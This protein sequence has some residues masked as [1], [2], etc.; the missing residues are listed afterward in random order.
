MP[1]VAQQNHMSTV[2]IPRVFVLNRGLSR[3]PEKPLSFP[4]MTLEVACEGIC[5]TALELPGSSS[6]QATWSRSS[7]VNQ[8]LVWLRNA[9]P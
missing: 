1:M 7:D 8:V 5:D 4:M 9:R 2:V 3:S 6:L